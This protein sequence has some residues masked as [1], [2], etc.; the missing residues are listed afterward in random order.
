MFLA[1]LDLKDAYFSIPIH[2]AHIK[3]LRFNFQ[4]KIYEY[5][6]LPFGLS[7][8]PFIFTK[9]LKPVTAYIR[10]KGIVLVQYIDDFLICGTSFNQCKQVVMATRKI[11]ESLGFITNYNK[12]V[13][14]PAMLCTYLGF[15]YDTKNMLVYLPDQKRLKII[16]MVNRF[17]KLK[18]SKVRELAS[19]IG[20]LVAACPAVK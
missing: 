1:K 10:S 3:Y 13:L 8:A 18:K 17:C 7:I 16:S 12:S 2:K 6:V 5:K 14:N 20:T 4:G 11:L 15:T 9:L 19:F